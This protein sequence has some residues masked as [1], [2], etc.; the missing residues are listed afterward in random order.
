[1]LATDQPPTAPTALSDC[2]MTTGTSKLDTYALT[3]GGAPTSPIPVTSFKLNE[4]PRPKSGCEGWRSTQAA[5]PE[6]RAG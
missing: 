1:M 4:R 3:V 6:R 2:R 5:S